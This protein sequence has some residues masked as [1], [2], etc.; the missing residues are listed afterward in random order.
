ME[1]FKDIFEFKKEIVKGTGIL[2]LARFILLPI[3]L[4]VSIILARLLEPIH[5]G[6]YGI[7]SLFIEISRRIS[8]QGLDAYLVQKYEP[9]DIREYRTVFTLR[10]IISIFFFILIWLFLPLLKISFK[11]PPEGILMARVLSSILIIGTFS[12][13]SAALLQR[14]LH[15]KKMGILEIILNLGYQIP[16]VVF[17]SLGFGAWSFIWASVI[18][19]SIYTISC[20]MLSPWKMGFFIYPPVIKKV[21]NF[22]SLFQLSSLVALIRDNIIPILG[23][24]FFGPQ[25]VGYLTWAYNSILRLC[26]IFHQIVGSITFSAIARIQNNSEAVSKFFFKSIRYLMLIT[27]PIMFIFFALTYEVIVIVFNP[28]WIPAIPGLILFG[29]LSLLG[30]FTTVGDNLLKGL[31]KVKENLLIMSIWTIA[32]WVISF[33]AIKLIGYNGIAWGWTLSALIPVIWIINMVRGNYPLDLRGILNPLLA[34]SIS[35]FLISLLKSLI[36]LNI[37][38]LFLLG[39][40]GLCLYLVLLWILE[41]KKLLKEILYLFNLLRFK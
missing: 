11:L 10:L 19:T 35:A 38:T 34:S 40:I 12:Q 22:G 9:P 32:S 2:F 24:I 31:G 8:T 21:L 37:S 36:K 29:C 16:A 39:G 41:E 33:L 1:E 25:A 27:A 13:V 17:A 30:H 26:C 6:I 4:I 23:G 7:L 5:F 20:F 18:S 3:S 15:F 28:K 14:K